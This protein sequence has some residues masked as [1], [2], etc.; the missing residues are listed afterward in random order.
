[1]RESSRSP[2]QPRRLLPDEWSHPEFLGQSWFLVRVALVPTM[3]VATPFCVIAVFTISQLM[4]MVGALD[5][6]GAATGITMVREIG[7]LVTVL[8]AWAGSTAMCA[9]LGARKIREEIDPLEVLGLETVQPQRTS[10]I[11]TSNPGTPTSTRGGWSPTGDRR[12]S[13]ARPPTPTSTYLAHKFWALLLRLFQT[14]PFLQ[15]P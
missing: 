9:D 2:I 8:V 14:S 1:V 10:P 6:A 13:S 11:S 5:L 7:P 15:T 3:L 4:A 12:P